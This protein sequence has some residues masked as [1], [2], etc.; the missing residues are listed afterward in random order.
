MDERQFHE[1][2]GAHPKGVNYEGET[3]SQCA[4]RLGYKEIA[5]L[6]IGF[7]SVLEE[8]GSNDG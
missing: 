5:Q 1:K 6:I 3:P 8:T 4:Q 7:G 2:H